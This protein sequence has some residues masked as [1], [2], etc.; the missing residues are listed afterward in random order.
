M[1]DNRE[2]K[3]DLI[4]AAGGIIIRQTEN[5]PE[6][7]LIHRHRYGSEWCLP[8]GKLKENETWQSAAIREIK[9]ETGCN[10]EIKGIAGTTHYTV[11]GKP[12]LVLY[13]LMDPV[14]EC[15]FE[16]SEEV[17]EISWLSPIDAIA[18][19]DHQ[20]EVELIRTSFQILE[21]RK[22]RPGWIGRIIIWIKRNLLSARIKRLSSEISV[23]KTELE[24]RM[25][26]KDT[27][28]MVKKC[29]YKTAAELLKMADSALDAVDIDTGWKC[30][31]AA[32]R[33]ELR[34]LDNDKDLIQRHAS[35]IRNESDKLSSWRKKAV[36]SLIGTTE[37]PLD[38]EKIKVEDLFQAALLR[39]GHYD[40]QAYKS[41]I[42]RRHI[43]RLIVLLT[44]LLVAIY[45]LLHEGALPEPSNNTDLA[46]T[47]FYV[48]LF[49]LLGGT[50]S[51]IL[52]VPTTTDSSR[53]PELIG[54]FQVMMLR[55]VTGGASAIIVFIFL[56]SQFSKDI[57]SFVT[58]E[59]LIDPFSIFAISFV[60]GF[61]ERLV[62]RAV[63]KIS[64]K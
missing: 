35:I 56:R 58:P 39:D 12:K 52:K 26:E 20:E 49:G 32:R 21:N 2:N 47:I 38:K 59:I 5:G 36:S 46:K 54:S 15:H 64:E 22:Q 29:G 24:E 33:M 9:E 57:F 55:L 41:G 19:L 51:A 53:I 14:G 63:E 3:I 40:N 44:V 18:R 8:K 4:Q 62:L 16:A 27:A 1:T 60:S 23:Y 42:V 30:L 10:C 45:Q 6:I 43:F 37:N 28:H 61:S 7:V 25:C 50:L 34:F 13:W 31:H 17:K 11:N 48:F